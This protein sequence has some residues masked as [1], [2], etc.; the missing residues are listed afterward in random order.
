[1]TKANDH[2]ARFSKNWI[3]VSSG[4]GRIRTA[5]AGV[6][7]PE[8]VVSADGLTVTYPQVWPGIDLRYLLLTDGVKEEIVV[9]SATVLP[10]DGRFSFDVTGPGLKLE[11]GVPRIEGDLGADIL[12]GGVEVL[13][14]A[15]APIS[16]PAVVSLAVDGR[17]NGAGVDKIDTLTVGVDPAWAAGLPASAFPI[18]VDPSNF[19]GPWIQNAEGDSPATGGVPDTWCAANPGCNHSRVGN[20]PGGFGDIFWHTGV[21]H[22][23]SAML[24]TGTVASTLT[25]SCHLVRVLR[26]QHWRFVR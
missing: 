16:T 19:W 5:P 23:Y 17:R 10:A 11:G 18:I 24:P 8:P 4:K 15:G 20:Q 14:K 6:V 2:V 9:T 1:V 25:A 3:E 26:H 13:D 21:G 7:L 12:F 22:D